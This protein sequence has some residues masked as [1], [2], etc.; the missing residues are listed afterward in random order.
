MIKKFSRVS[1]IFFT[2]FVTLMVMISCIS[3][4]FAQDTTYKLKNIGITLNLPEN[5]QAITRDTKKDNQVF[6]ILKFDY[7]ETMDRFRTSDI[8][9]QAVDTENMLT[10]TVSMTTTEGTKA[11]D[12]YNSLTQKELNTVKKGFMEDSSYKSGIKVQFNGST[13]LRF[14]V[15]TTNGTETVHSQQYNTVSNGNNYVISIQ[16]SNGEELT[17]ADKAIIKGIMNSVIINKPYSS[18]PKADNSAVV[19]TVIIVVAVIG[20]IILVIVLIRY[21]ISPQRK[22]KKLLHQLAHEHKISETT[23]IP[24]KKLHSYM[25]KNAPEETDFMEEFEPLD[26]VDKKLGD[27]IE[28]KKQFKEIAIPEGSKVNSEKSSEDSAEVIEQIREFE[29]GT[30][31]LADIPDKDDMYVYTDV[32]TAVEDYKQAK[33]VQQRRRRE[34]E[35]NKSQPKESTVLKVLKTVLLGIVGIIQGI[36]MGICYVIVH[37]KYFSINLYRL[38][39]R[40]RA[41]KKRKKIIEEKRRKEEERLQMRREAE[42]RRRQRNSQRGENDLIQVRSRSEGRTYPRSG[43]YDRNYN[44]NRR[45]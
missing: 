44:R 9:L 12:N 35:Q 42:M 39:K 15:E 21:F 14:D 7:Q 4:A 11:V 22:N 43:G 41:E 5:M 37:L 45:K 28:V 33:R 6:Q 26:S 24:R 3:P 36:F 29:L 8:Y 16:A 19:R 10:V 34:A 1:K 27:T 31:Y 40:K 25:L 32:E 2:L 30:D 23:Q 38:I 18:A 13:Y 20:A 17:Q